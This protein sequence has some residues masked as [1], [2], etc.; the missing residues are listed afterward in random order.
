MNE[1]IFENF[2]VKFPVDLKHFIFKDKDY[3]GIIFYY[4]D[5]KYELIHNYIGLTRILI[6][7]PNFWNQDLPF[8]KNT[9]LFL[10]ETIK[11]EELQ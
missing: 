1:F 11:F 7:G 9:I 4:K 5:K 2:I 6:N 8:N 10:P 3:Y